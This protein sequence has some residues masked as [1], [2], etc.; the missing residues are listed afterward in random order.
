MSAPLATGDYRNALSGQGPLAY[1]WSDKPHRLVY[2][3]CNEVEALR[4]AASELLTAAFL[5]RDDPTDET[6]AERFRSC[7]AHMAGLLPN[8]DG[9]AQS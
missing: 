1:E 7:A 2:D 9:E 4:A 3:L 6:W 8:P 5:L